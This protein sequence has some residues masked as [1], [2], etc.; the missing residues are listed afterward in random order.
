MVAGVKTSVG[1]GGVVLGGSWLSQYATEI[2]VV[3]M[4]IGALCSIGGLV[5][6]VWRGS[7]K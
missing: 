4:I 1:G 7:K 5:Y 3:C 2:G 6:T